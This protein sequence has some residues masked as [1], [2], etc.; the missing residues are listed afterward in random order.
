MVQSRLL[1]LLNIIECMYIPVCL[2]FTYI[3]PIKEPMSSSG[4]ISYGVVK[5]DVI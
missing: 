2:N 5:A 3:K 4:I 1:K